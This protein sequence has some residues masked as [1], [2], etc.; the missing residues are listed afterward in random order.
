MLVRVLPLTYGDD[1]CCACVRSGEPTTTT[2][3][4]GESWEQTRNRESAW[5]TSTLLHTLPPWPPCTPPGASRSMATLRGQ[6]CRARRATT[7]M[8]ERQ[9]HALT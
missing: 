3:S 5:A 1:Q 4:M 8:S 6:A 9:S 2:T 7:T